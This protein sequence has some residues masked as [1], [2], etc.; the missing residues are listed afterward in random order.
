MAEDDAPKIQIDSDWKAEARKEKERLASRS[1]PAP[2][3]AK[4]AADKATSSTTSGGGAMPKAGFQTLLST[5]VTQAL[6]A[7]GAIPDPATGQRMAHLDLA[8]HHID[9]LAVLEEKTKGNLSQ[10][11]ADALTTSLYELRNQYVM[12]A[13]HAR[14]QAMAEASAADP[15]RP[16]K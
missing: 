14:R 8:R 6:F 15:S 12:L 7:M 1:A 2:G 11:E 10:E 5:M 13:E 9:L 4:G 16:I 3:T